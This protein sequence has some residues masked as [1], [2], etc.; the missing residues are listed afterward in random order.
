VSDDFQDEIGC[1]GIDSSPAFV[2]APEGNGYAERIIRT[3]K[4]Q[5]LWVHQFD[6]AEALR[7]ALV[8][9][10]EIYNTQ[11]L[12]ERHGHITPAQARAR[13]YETPLTAAA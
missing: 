4:E 12:I 5:V 1:L 9:W 13:Y 11:G 6:N 2:R 8:D 7:K 3:L 10:A